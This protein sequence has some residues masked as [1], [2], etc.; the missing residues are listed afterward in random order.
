MDEVARER[1]R[2][3]TTS[4][5]NHAKEITE[6]LEPVFVLSPDL[7]PK[8]LKEMGVSDKVSFVE[9]LLRLFPSK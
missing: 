7:F 8:N 3:L 9:Q 1:L 5:Y 2:F 4:I 6:L